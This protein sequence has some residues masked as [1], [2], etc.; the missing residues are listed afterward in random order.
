MTCSIKAVPSL[1]ALRC[2][3]S[4]A[5][6][7][8]N[9]YIEARRHHHSWSYLKRLISVCSQCDIV[10]VH[11]RCG[12]WVFYI[13]M[14]FGAWCAPVRDILVVLVI[15]SASVLHHVPALDEFLAGDLVANVL[16]QIPISH[17][18]PISVVVSPLLWRGVVAL[19]V[20][21]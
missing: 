11:V 3:V 5:C 16:V 1:K 21:E 10:D 14:R 7:S 20:E 2:L 12:R 13:C 15:R 6:R 8:V 18:I 4:V 17:G 9:D 19:V